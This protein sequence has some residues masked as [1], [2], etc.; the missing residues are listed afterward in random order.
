MHNNN[1]HIIRE[2]KLSYLL[3]Q[4]RMFWIVKLQYSTDKGGE[5]RD[6]KKLNLSRIIVAVQ[7]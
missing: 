6:V 5:M 3:V 1:S 4:S 2:T 7:V